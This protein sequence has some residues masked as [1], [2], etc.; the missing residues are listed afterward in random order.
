MRI[1]AGVKIKRVPALEAR[2]RLG[3]LINEAHSG[4]V[5]V[6]VEKLEVPM[7]GIISAEEYQR[8][9]AERE[10]R[11][12]VIERIRAKLPRVPE[13]DLQRDVRRTLREVRHR[14]RAHGLAGREPLG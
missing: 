2:S 1:A 11:F 3:A 6:L 13:A 14:R 7:V 10:A 12:E 9:I 5:R 4:K 8:M